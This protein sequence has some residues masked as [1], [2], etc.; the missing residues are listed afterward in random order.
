M[1]KNNKSLLA[2]LLTIGMVATGCTFTNST[3]N[4]TSNNK[5]S[6][7]SKIENSTK[8]LNAVQN[9]NVVRDGDNLVVTFDAVENASGYKLEVTKDDTVVV[10]EQDITS[11]GTLT[12]FADAGDY[13]ISV[14]AVGDQTNYLN[15]E[16]T[17]FNYKVEIWVDYVD[18]D[19]STWNARLEQGA[20]V[21]EANWRAQNGDTYVGT[22]D[23]NFNRVEG[24]FTYSNGM[25]YVGGF[26]NNIFHDEEDGF[27]SWSTNGDY[28]TANSYYGPIINGTSDGQ[29]GTIFGA[30]YWKDIATVD[31]FCYYTGEIQG[32]A[33]PK[34]GANGKFK[35]AYGVNQYYE[36]DCYI[37]TNW[38]FKRIGQGEN[39]WNGNSEAAGWF[40]GYTNTTDTVLGSKYF[41]RYVGGFDDMNHG[42]FYGNGVMYIKNADG[43]PY[44]YV[45]GNWDWAAANPLTEWTDFDP[46]TDLLEA[47]R[48]D[49]VLNLTKAF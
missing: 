45:V 12:P 20:I 49:G 34:V 29:V 15:S 36:G 13:V 42:W 10:S 21:G 9:L 5:T 48:A 1:R 7:S 43:T 25:F 2:M 17:S 6:S 18:T 39:V 19:G 44:G 33:E 3:P 46:A 37:A 4:T 22:F 38:N 26:L 47:Y 23:A 41:D 27:F 24:K 35:W 16:T 31:G 30:N 28:T 11:G 14:K 40:A 32:M 8:T